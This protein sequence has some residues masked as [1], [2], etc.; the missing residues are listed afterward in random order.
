[1]ARLPVHRVGVTTITTPRINTEV[2]ATSR[3]PCRLEVRRLRVPNTF[4]KAVGQ[5]IERLGD[6]GYNLLG[7]QMPLEPVLCPAHVPYFDGRGG[8]V[9][10]V[11]FASLHTR[12]TGSRWFTRVA[13]LWPKDH[14]SR[15]NTVTLVPR[16][17]AL[18]RGFTPDLRKCLL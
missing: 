6:R 11:K 13:I 3:C 2:S 8:W 15:I 16:L 5:P 7:L 9:L 17:E 12:T 4:S 10:E 14:F 18:V 1:V